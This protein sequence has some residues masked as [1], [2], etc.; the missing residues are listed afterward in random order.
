MRQLTNVAGY[1]GGPFFSPDGQWVI[2][3][4]DR[5]KED[6]LQLF[7]ISV[8]GK[9]EV[10]LTDDL[11]HGQLGPYFHPSGKYLV[12]TRADYSPRPARA[13][14]SICARWRSSTTADTLRRRRDHADH[15]D[16][17]ADVLPVFSPDGKQADVDHQP[18]RGRVSS[19]LW[20]ADWL[21]E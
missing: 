11:E 15:V 5:E 14:T 7:A 3:R 18:H 16:H 17:K 19:Q 1:D 2:F 21:R 10:Q 20:I 6:M 13:R 9:P 4:S 12:W 8:D